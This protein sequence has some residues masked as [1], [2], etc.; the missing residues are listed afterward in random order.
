MITQKKSLKRESQR[1]PK[2]AWHYYYHTTICSTTF[3]QLRMITSF[4]PGTWYLVNNVRQ[5]KKARKPRK[6]YSPSKVSS[7]AMLDSF[8]WLLRRTAPLDRFAFGFSASLLRSSALSDCTTFTCYAWLSAWLEGGSCTYRRWRLLGDGKQRDL[9]RQL[10]GETTPHTRVF[11][12][13][14]PCHRNT[15]HSW[16]HLFTGDQSK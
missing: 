10:R 1:E 2:T 14:H 4:I 7:T 12:V 11:I 3:N 9:H 13:F 16:K 15:C 8:A 6:I 5:K